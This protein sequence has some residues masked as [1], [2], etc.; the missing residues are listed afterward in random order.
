MTLTRVY[1]TPGA[2]ENVA[3]TNMRFAIWLLMRQ[4]GL[5]KI[6]L[7][8]LEVGHTHFDV[9]Q[10]HAVFSISLRTG[11]TVRTDVHSLSQYEVRAREAHKDLIE[12][13]E[14]GHLF[15]FDSW[16]QPMRNRL[17]DGIQVQFEIYLS[18]IHIHSFIFINLS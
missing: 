6:I 3:K 16:L 18:T 8:R 12:F 1:T 15:D 13:V 7:S 17:E 4:T 2:S 14:L 10:R 5:K 9:D 11:G